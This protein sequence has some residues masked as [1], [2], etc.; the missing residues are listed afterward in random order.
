[1]TIASRS[2]ALSIRINER[3][4]KSKVLKQSVNFKYSSL[5]F[6]ICVPN[7]I[8]Q[9]KVEEAKE[10]AREMLGHKRGSAAVYSYID[11]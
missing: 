4:R 7:L 11:V 9:K 2:Q 6:R 10:E 8:Y 5:M 1:M 3:I